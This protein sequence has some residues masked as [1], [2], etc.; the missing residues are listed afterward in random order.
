MPVSLT[1][2]EEFAIWLRVIGRG[3]CDYGRCGMAA[4]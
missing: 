3:A 1:N 2:N 4:C